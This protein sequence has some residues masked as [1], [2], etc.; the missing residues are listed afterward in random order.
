PALRWVARGHSMTPTSTDNPGPSGPQWD[1]EGGETEEEMEP[2]QP[3]PDRL[4]GPL[5]HTDPPGG[6]PPAAQVPAMLVPSY[7]RFTF[8]QVLAS[9]APALDRV[10]LGVLA[11]GTPLWC[12]ARDLC[13]VALAG[14]TGG[15]KS[16]ILRLLLA[17]L[18]HGGA[19]VLLL[20][21]HYTHFDRE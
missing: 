3:R 12:A 1:N 15:G 10:F 17:H 20:N 4:A 16:S 8:S 9:H 5:P 18:C 2:L 11:D 7:G 14:A 19:S 13:H 21:P 6:E